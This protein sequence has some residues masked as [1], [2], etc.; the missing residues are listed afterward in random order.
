[1][2]TPDIRIVISAKLTALT[3]RARLGERRPLRVA[4]LGGYFEEYAEVQAR[5]AVRA[6]AAALG[7]NHIVTLPLAEAGRASAFVITAAE[8]G[9]LHRDHL[10]TQ[11]ASMEPR[12]RDRLA[13]GAAIPAGW[14]LQAQQVRARYRA[15][16]LD[17]FA[18]FDVLIAAS[19]PLPAT[20]IGTETM[21]I[22][23]R[24]LPVRAN[25]GVLTQPISC[26]GLPVAAVPIAHGERL[27]IGVQLAAGFG[28]DAAL[29]DFA[30]AMQLWT[31]PPSLPDP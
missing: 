20:P 25:I 3:A 2:F 22:N 8:G 7:A 18:R 31:P 30:A 16:V 23:G 15:Q 12:S 17:L 9:A 26:V 14:Y 10:R 21:T 28:A 13:A 1:M 24:E 27:P 11:Y 5:A 4:V 29:L 19:T 6:A